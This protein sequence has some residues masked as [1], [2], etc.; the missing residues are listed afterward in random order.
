MDR[1][2]DTGLFYLYAASMVR[3]G[4]YCLATA[5]IWYILSITGR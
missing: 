5:V 2:I 4:S 3:A 1:S